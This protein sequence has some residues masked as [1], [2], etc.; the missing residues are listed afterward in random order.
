[1]QLINWDLTANDEDY[2]KEV[3]IILKIKKKGFI[4]RC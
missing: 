2:I 1:M 4:I 3:E